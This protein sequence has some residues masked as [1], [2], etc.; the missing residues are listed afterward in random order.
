MHDDKF[1]GFKGQPTAK[2]ISLGRF[3]EPGEY[4]GLYDTDLT[5]KSWDF[6]QLFFGFNNQPVG[7]GFGVG[8][9]RHFNESFLLFD[10]ERQVADVVHLEIGTRRVVNVP[11]EDEE[12]TI[13]HTDRMRQHL[14]SQFQWEV[15]D[16]KIYGDKPVLRAILT[17][18]GAE[19]DEL[20]QAVNNLKNKRWINKAEGVQLDGLGEIVVRNR[21]IDEAIAVQLFGFWG[22]P[23]VVGFGQARFRQTGEDNL[24]TYILADAEYRLALAMK[25]AVNSSRGTA[26]DTISSLRYAFNAPIRMEEIGNANIIVSIG[27]ELTDNERLL[28]NALDM[29]IRAG[30]VG[31]KYKSYFNINHYFGFLGQPNAKGFG[32]G[33]FAHVF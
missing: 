2:G 19:M 10:T 15:I 12:V 14:I 7:K 16:D 18:L 1:L 33:Q 26:E 30:G 9:F 27:R 13:D 32:V 21:Q 17:A 8:R 28:A 22:Q 3:R 4:L 24:Q 31:L 6:G 29:I 5:I 23:N 25:V 20:N 11:R